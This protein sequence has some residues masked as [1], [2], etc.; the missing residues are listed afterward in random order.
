[1]LLFVLLCQIKQRLM[2]TLGDTVANHFASATAA[3][4]ACAV[5]SSPFDVVKTTPVY[6]VA[7]VLHM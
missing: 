6:K 4:F 3:G 2:P 5:A 1:M 7:F